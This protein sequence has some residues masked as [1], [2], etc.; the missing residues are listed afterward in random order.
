MDRDGQGS[1][2]QLGQLKTGQDGKGLL[3]GHLWCHID[4]AK[5][6]DR[7]NK[8]IKKKGKNRCLMLD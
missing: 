7:M 3:R 6:W 8:K 4:L 2:A 1:P 5:L